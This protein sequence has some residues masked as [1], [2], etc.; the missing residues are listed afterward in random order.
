MVGEDEKD[1]PDVSTKKSVRMSK[2]TSDIKNLEKSEK[3]AQR[4]SKPVDIKK[5]N[6][7]LNFGM[8][9]ADSRS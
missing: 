5:R 7:Y 4:E 9:A 1:L 2:D 8:P 3:S 6:S